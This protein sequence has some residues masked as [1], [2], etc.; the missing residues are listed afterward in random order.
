MKIELSKRDKCCIFLEAGLIPLRIISRPIEGIWIGISG[1][2][3]IICK[4]PS[5]RQK[6]A[7]ELKNYYERQIG[8]TP[9]YP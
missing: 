7:E 2:V 8:G 1:N 9:N 6:V 4:W 3:T 5:D